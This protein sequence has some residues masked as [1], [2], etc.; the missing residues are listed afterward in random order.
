VQPFEMCSA[1]LV[2]QRS[3]FPEQ[4]WDS[5]VEYCTS[6]ASFLQTSGCEL[7]ADK[8]ASA[9]LQAGCALYSFCHVT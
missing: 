9:A 2:A 3:I 7:E 8:F 5:Q 4:N 1:L 6:A